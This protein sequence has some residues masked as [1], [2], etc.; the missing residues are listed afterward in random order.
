MS[1]Y[2]IDDIDS[3][4]EQFVAGRI[5]DLHRQIFPEKDQSFIRRYIQY[6]SKMFRGEH[7]KYQK[8]DTRYHD[9][10]HTFQATLCWVQLVVNR[11]KAGVEP[12]MSAEDFEIGYVAI[13]FHDIGYLKEMGD[14][15]GTGA[16]FT[17]VHEIRS[18]EMVEEYLE[19]I[20]WPK[21]RI[22]K[23][24]HLISCTGPRSVIDAIPF[25]SRLERI[26]GEAVCSADYI[27]QMSDPGY[28]DKLSVLFDEFE[29][30]DD[31]RGVPKEQR[32]FKDRDALIRGTPGFWQNVI[33]DKLE[34]DCHG[35]YRFLAEPYPDGPNPYL[36]S[37]ERNIDR[38][39]LKIEAE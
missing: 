34:A 38:V 25:R 9:L 39:Q 11:H 26:I 4:D 2:S 24:R 30:S 16:K 23:V 37:I 28:V 15:E 19:M 36:E 33:L 1:H 21:E 6:L 27:G 22:V 17:F 7:P 29:E 18:A 32:L 35:L 8:M 31:Y 10:E 5:E 14:H 13:L 20:E 3:S 12:M